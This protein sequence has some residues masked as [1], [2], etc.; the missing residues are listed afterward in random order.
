MYS[1]GGYNYVGYACGAN[2]AFYNAGYSSPTWTIVLVLFIVL[3]ILTMI[4]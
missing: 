2:T 3:V 1:Y 4:L